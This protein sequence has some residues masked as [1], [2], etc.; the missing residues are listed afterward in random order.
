VSIQ[1]A[2][3]HRLVFVNMKRQCICIVR[4]PALKPWKGCVKYEVGGGNDTQWPI[5]WL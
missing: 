1:A 4:V 5:D 2:S 3:L